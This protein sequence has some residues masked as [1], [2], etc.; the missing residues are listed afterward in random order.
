MSGQAG[1]KLVRFAAVMNMRN[2]VAG[3]TGMGAVMGSKNLKAIAVRGRAEAGDRQPGRHQE[4][5]HVGSEGVQSQP[6][7]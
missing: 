7:Y 3:R 2:R 6:R 1:E 4:D 5:C